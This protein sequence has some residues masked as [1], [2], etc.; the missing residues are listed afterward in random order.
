MV[1]KGVSGIVASAILLSLTIAGGVLLYTYVTRYLNTVIDE[2]NVVVERSYYVKSMNRLSI[3][4]KNIGIGETEIKS[5]EVLYSDSSEIYSENTK[6][7][8]G[9]S[10]TIVKYVNKTPLYVVIRYGKNLATDPVPVR[11]I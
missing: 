8:P 9:S 2:G 6:L 5:I 1:L 3:D 11:V 7:G 4:V 10:I